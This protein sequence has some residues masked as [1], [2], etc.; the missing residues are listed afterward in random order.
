MTNKNSPPEKL[1][2]QAD[3]MAYGIKSLEQN[4]KV[5]ER[6]YIKFGVAMD[7]KLL[8][9][10]IEWTVIRDTSAEALS[11]LIMKHMQE[12]TES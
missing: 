5:K 4:M 7:D 11:A 8:T 12:K 1:K 10:Q 3:R 6:P 9:M 2:E